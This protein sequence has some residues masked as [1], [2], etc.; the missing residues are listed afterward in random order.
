MREK[1]AR[2]PRF[3]VDA[4]LKAGARVE[5]AGAAARQASEVTFEGKPVAK[6]SR[7]AVNQAFA[8]STDVVPDGAEVEVAGRTA[9]SRPRPA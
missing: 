2:T 5:L 4:R 9:T 8:R 1:P 7:V 6:Q 3:Y